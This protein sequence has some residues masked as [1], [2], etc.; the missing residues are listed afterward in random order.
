MKCAELYFHVLLFVIML[1]GSSFWVCERNSEVWPFKWKLLSSTFKWYSLPCNMVLM[2]EY[3]DKILKC[4]EQYFHVV[5][6][7]TLFTVVL[8]FESVDEILKCDH[9]NESN[10]AVRSCGTVYY[11]VHGGSY[12]WV[13]GWHPKVWPFK[14]KLL[15][16][17]FTWYGLLHCWKWFKYSSLWSKS[18]SVT[19][20]M[21][22]TEQ[23]FPV[24]LFIKL[25]KVVLTFESVDE[26]LKWDHS[27]ES[28]WA[29]LSRATLLYVVQGYHNI[30]CLPWL[31]LVQF[32][33]IFLEGPAK[34]NMIFFH[35]KLSLFAIDWT[36]CNPSPFVSTDSFVNKNFTTHCCSSIALWTLWSSLATLTLKHNKN[37]K[38]VLRGCVTRLQNSQ[39]YSQNRFSIV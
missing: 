15:S 1:C 12:F 38:K 21:K 18:C 29:V 39:F 22:S 8:A 9:S 30:L 17:T 37:G 31:L 4:D 3:V 16:S 5:L 24:V 32:G 6:F 28:Y 2:F 20:Q 14:W 27:N 26:I 23:D 11:A 34:I 19:I 10:W 7:T 36:M 13:G 33:Q 25:Y 35:T